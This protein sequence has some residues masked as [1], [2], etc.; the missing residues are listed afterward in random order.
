MKHLCTRMNKCL[1][2]FALLAFIDVAE[3]RRPGKDKATEI[4][5]QSVKRNAVNLLSRKPKD[6]D[7]LNEARSYDEKVEKRHF[8]G[9]VLAYVTPWNAAGYDNAK[10]FRR[11]FSHVSPVWYNIKQDHRSSGVT[12]TGQHDV[13]QGWIKAVRGKGDGPKIVPRFMFEGWD[14]NALDS[15]FGKAKSV[16][17]LTNL[18]TAE[19]Q[20]Q[21]FD[22]LVLEVFN[23]IDPRSRNYQS[24]MQDAKYFILEL[25]KAL[26][27]HKWQLVLV[28]P[29]NFSEDEFVPLAEHVDLFSLMTYDFSDR[30]RPGPNSPLSWV[31]DVVNNLK[32]KAPAETAVKILAGLNFYGNRYCGQDDD[33]P[34]LGRD[35][36]QILQKQ[37]TKFSWEEN[38]HEHVL[39]YNDNQRSCAVWYPTLQ[40]V[41]DRIDLAI[42][43]GTGLSIW[44]IGQ[45][46]EY[47]F[48]LL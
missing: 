8:S 24:L 20:K 5:L 6:S 30:R 29:P 39:R 42:D 10:L 48:D 22:G 11:K 3:C 37:K 13:D 14:S 40:S 36:L 35:Y 2:I 9:Q 18:L 31:A 45:G 32:R 7:I 27:E 46:L 28:I 23:S 21:G 33:G 12:I 38:F 47:F 15:L 26:H 34:I 4:E 41:Q 19:V 44:E 43:L 17:D 1:C 16:K 25:A